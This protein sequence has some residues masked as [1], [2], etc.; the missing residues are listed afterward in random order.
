MILP[1]DGEGSKATHPYI[2]CRGL[3]RKGLDGR[4]IHFPAPC[5]SSAILAH[6]N[7]Q[8]TFQRR[9]VPCDEKKQ[10]GENWLAVV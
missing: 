9:K 5:G 10:Q 8:R 3:Y 1:H 7:D 2:A 4:G 6:L